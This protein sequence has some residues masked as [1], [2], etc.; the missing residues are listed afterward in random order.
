[1]PWNG[2]KLML[3]GW[4]AADWKIIKPLLD[5][6]TMPNLKALM[7]RGASGNLGSL[8]PMLSPMLWTSIATGKSADQ[9]GI[10]GFVEPG[11]EGKGVRPV[12]SSARKSRAI[13][14]ILHHEGLRTNV[15][16]WFAS[17][18][19][20]PVNGA[21]VTDLYPVGK[22]IGPAK[23]PPVAPQSI[24]PERLIEPL[25]KLRLH[26]NELTATDY[27]P[28]LAENAPL[29]MEKDAELMAK[30]RGLLVRLVRTHGAATAL[31]EKEPWD[32]FSTYYLTIDHTCHEFMHYRAPRRADIDE[33][34][35]E[36][37]KDVVTNMYRFH[38]MMLGSLLRFADDDTYVLLCSDHGFHS[39]HLRP[40]GSAEMDKQ[41]VAWH[42]QMGMMCLAGPGIKAGEP[43]HGATLMDLCPTMLSL[44]GLPVGKDMPGNVLVQ[45]M[46]PPPKVEAI[47]SWEDVE[48]DFAQVE[49]TEAQDPAA[50]A[51][52]LKQLIDL[53][54]LEDVGDDVD[55]QAEKAYTEQQMNL[56]GVLMAQGRDNEAMAVYEAMQGR[57]KA[58]RLAVP[59]AQVLMQLG[60]FAEAEAKLDAIEEDRSN[61]K[62]IYELMQVRALI[63]QGKWDEANALVEAQE[64]KEP[65]SPE[66]Q[67]RL[68][69][70]LRGMQQWM[71]ALRAY[72]R[73][74][75]LDPD[76][77]QAHEGRAACLLRM[78]QW[79]QA[80]EAAYSA[81]ELLFYQPDAHL[82]LG[83]ALA[84]LGM[85]REAVQALSVRARMQP[86]SKRAHRL[87]AH[88]MTEM[89]AEPFARG[90][91]E[92]YEALLAEE[93]AGKS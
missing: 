58:K 81:I 46:D 39:D 7:D 28:F 70:T 61:F 42:R 4:D 45:L 72:E 34:Q 33:R 9:H 19:A 25:E 47:D 53:G 93:L 1:M 85:M 36:V 71:R 30:L 11:P 44:L 82:I 13:W 73:A 77:P 90:H 8:Q 67:V 29:D 41:P 49:Y 89:G 84:R 80:R 50:A 35:F 63:N 65:N 6:G 52:A 74:S 86:P 21:V 26:P 64:A 60:R 43:I 32:F 54:Y 83:V 59:M 76:N 14:N 20:E 31:A 48:G 91:R 92:R 87:L 51:E 24:H 56:G 15:V 23:L 66:V 12:S 3:I 88:L 37:F 17:H 16:G 40:P 27:A 78:R 38:D 62:Q 2:K 68:G 57:V 55:E 5:D 79:D 22:P 18:P 10:L 69:N 75:A